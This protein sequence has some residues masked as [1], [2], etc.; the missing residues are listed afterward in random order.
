M[1][2][3]AQIGG[4]QLV[5]ALEA[6]RGQRLHH[7]ELDIEQRRQRADIDD[8][9]VELTLPWVGIWAAQISVSGM[10]STTMSSRML[11]AAADGSIVEKV[12][13][14]F[15][16]G[17]ILREGLRV[18]GDEHIGAAPRA[19][20]PFLAHPH[21]IPGRQALD[22]RGKDVARRDRHAHPQD[23]TRNRTLALAD[24]EPLTLAK[25]MTKSFTRGS[26]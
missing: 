9:L 26:A 15:E 17:D 20:P 16:R 4:D 11:R 10:P 5:L 18:H 6:S 14:A 19:E 23:R 21:F 13:A 1:L 25:R 8:V 22:V 2:Q 24:P 7:P 12:A 3:R